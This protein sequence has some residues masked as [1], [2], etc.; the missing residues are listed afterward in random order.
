MHIKRQNGL[1]STI[2]GFLGAWVVASF[3]GVLTQIGLLR[4]VVW[5]VFLACVGLAV[6]GILTMLSMSSEPNKDVSKERK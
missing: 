5:T 3:G 6:Y 2:G 4:I 1:V